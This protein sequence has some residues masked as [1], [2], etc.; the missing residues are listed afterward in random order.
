M[1]HKMPDSGTFKVSAL[2]R[3]TTGEFNYSV[4]ASVGPVDKSAA[5][6]ITGSI[7]WPAER[8]VD[9]SGRQNAAF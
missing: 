1:W 4:T 8:K 6:W 2:Y 7:V 9:E 3:C 5:S